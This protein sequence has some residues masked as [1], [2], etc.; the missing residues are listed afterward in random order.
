MEAVECGAA[1]LGIILGY[2]GRIVPLA[3]LREQCGVSRDGSKASNIVKAAR[4]YGLQAKGFSKPLDSMKE[5]TCPYIVFW[6]FNHF[7][8]VEGFGRDVVYL[9][10]PALG[11]RRITWRE[12]DEGF[13]GVVLLMEPTDE[14][15]RQGRRPSTL[16]G[17]LRRVRGNFSSLVLI[18]LA[19]LLAV[20]PG[21]AIPTMMGVYLD[22]VII[23][24]HFDWFRPL[25]IAMAA[26]VVLKLVLQAVQQFY[27]RRLQI[28]LMARLNSQFFWHLLR[29]P[30]RFYTQRFAGEIVNRMDLNTKLANVVAGPLV[31]TVIDLVTMVVYGIVLL[32]F[33]L[34][35]TLIATAFATINLLYLRRVARLRVEANIRF[36]QEAG[37]LEGFTI[38][39]IQSIETMKASGM[40]DDFF[41]KWMGYFAKSSNAGQELQ[42]SS[43]LT[44]ILPMVVDVMTTVLIL[45]VGGY[46]VIHGQMT[47]GIL[48]AYQG[49][50]ASY[51]APVARLTNLGSTLQELRGDLLR[52]DDVLANPPTDD[53]TL[54]P[55]DRPSEQAPTKLRLEGE[56]ELRDVTFGYSPLEPPLIENLSVHVRPGERVAF[57]G[58]SGSGKSTIARLIC[59]LYEPW[60][61]RIL[62][63]GQPRRDLPPNVFSQSVAMVEQQIMLFEGTLRE[64]LTLWDRT[65]PDASLERAS[66]DAH[67]EDVI[68]NLP[69]TFSATLT[70]G[71]TNLSGGQRQRLEI[72]RALVAGPSILVLDEA[73]SA[74]DSETETI[75]DTN[76]RRRSCTCVIIAHRLSTIRDCN[77]I[78]VLS[79]G[80]VVERGTHEQLW[81]AGGHYRALLSHQDTV[82]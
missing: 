68:R 80:K 70:E 60:S 18:A 12:F 30:A 62:F 29:L 38:A 63:D 28:S 48:V 56:L 16:R 77:E 57:V 66:Q 75:I 58:E 73:T 40:E 5:L 49:L 51:L 2:H 15:Q 10:D 27:M 21:L 64:N 19:G 35:L 74:L 11:H 81:K 8:V 3:Q 24:G 22:S 71:G 45:I 34:P 1:A 43:Q 52:L 7:V 67:L 69:G 20:L 4:L 25:I 53:T 47:I 37:K 13:T 78:I 44:Q 54:S 36:S 33:N 82:E 26:T 23:E 79:R 17:L 41:A 32:L 39:G 76:L 14:F 50:M 9:N 61:G 72:A 55:I 46:S 6:Q 31:G 65:V 42:Y 59:G